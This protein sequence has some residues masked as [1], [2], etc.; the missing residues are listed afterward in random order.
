MTARP[1]EVLPRSAPAAVGEHVR[2]RRRDWRRIL[3][4]GV[5]GLV[6][7]G[8]VVVAGRA[9][10]APVAVTLARAEE[11][12]VK[13]EVPGPGT[14]EARYPVSVGS[15]I[16]GVLDK[17]LVDVGDEVQKGQ[18]LATL[19]RRELDA[20][21]DASRRAVA[22][23]AQEIVVAEA[24]LAKAQSDLSLAQITY[25][26]TNTL[27][28]QGL[29]SRQS[30]DESRAAMTAADAT[31]RAASVAIEARR[32]DLAGLIAQQHVA[33]TLASY[34]EI[35][36]PM[37]AIITR[38]L[39]EAGTAVSPGTAVYDMVDP[40][41]LWVAARIDESLTGG[42][43]V[44][45]RAVIHLRSGAEAAA[46]VVRVTMQADPV[47]RELEVDVGFDQRP[48]RFAIHEE[49]DVTIFGDETHGVVVP[50][51]A[52]IHR[53]DGAHVMVVDGGRARD[54]RAQ[55]GPSGGGRVRVLEGLNV[56]ESVVLETGAVHDGSRLV[57]K[58]A[59]RG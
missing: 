49:A 19:D 27:V 15:R 2:Q 32:A 56:G 12:T 1:I 53:A 5:I 51:A 48:A 35:V 11:G 3:R 46:H 37:H 25:E 47:T 44:G 57:D 36:S 18:V 34:A 10:T 24:N 20:R 22:S 33:E 54:R 41:S 21:A 17:V 13:A 52:I 23:A 31:K 29:V 4:T 16:T 58:G 43:N 40:D 59:P 42:L 50:L 39:L 26:R 8:G 28:G 55:L 14:V 45:Q 6:I 38:R 30:F 9:A 7:A